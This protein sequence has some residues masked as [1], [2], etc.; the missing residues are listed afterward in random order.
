MVGVQAAALEPGA[1]AAV[2]AACDAVH[3]PTITA[4][5]E[6][7]LA[8]GKLYAGTDDGRVWMTENDGDDWS[9]LTD[10]FGGVPEGTYVTRVKASNH[11]SN[12]VYVTFDGH[13]TNDFTPYVY[14]SDDNG[15]SFQSIVS[16]LPSGSVDFLHVVEEDPVNQ[17][18]LFV[19]SDVGAYVSTNRGG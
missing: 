11:D 13:R 9:E 18:L 10:K 5:D 17:N 15:N 7:P 8:S 19:G 14:V 1:A 16:D 3:Q 12:R 6:S 4:L 2:I